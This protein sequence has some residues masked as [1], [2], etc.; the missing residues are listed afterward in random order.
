MMPYNHHVV[1]LIPASILSGM[2]AP[3]LSHSVSL[4]LFIFN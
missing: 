1:D 2:S 4:L 3:L